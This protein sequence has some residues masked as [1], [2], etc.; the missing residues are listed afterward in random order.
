MSGNISGVKA[1]IQQIQPKAYYHHCRAHVL[2]LVVATSCKALPEIRNLF[3]SVS[4]LTWFLD[5]SAKRMA[6]VSR[7]L[8]G[9][10]TDKLVISGNNDDEPMLSDT[11]IEKARKKHSIQKLCETRWTARANTLSSLIAKYKS[12]TQSLQDILDESSASDA[13]IKASA[14]L[15]ML[16]SS[17]FI[18]ALVV[19]QHILSFTRPLT[20]VLQKTDCDIIKAY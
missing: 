18:V 3:D 15:R 12:I 13:R 8:S 14:H 6:I 7:Y 11:L 10:D 19:T 5:G 2:N 4:H 1:R 17:Q 20:Q 9:D 16:Q